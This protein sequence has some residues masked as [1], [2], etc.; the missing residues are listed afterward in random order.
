LAFCEHGVEREGTF[1]APTDA[2]QADKL[3]ARQYKIDITKVVFA[4]AFDDDIRS[5]HI[6]TI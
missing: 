6:A 2:S 1:A 3:V 4:S 5:G